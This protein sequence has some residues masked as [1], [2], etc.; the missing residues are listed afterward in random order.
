MLPA[1]GRLLASAA[2]G[3]GQGRV[4]PGRVV[5]ARGFHRDQ[6]EPA[7]EER[8][9]VL[10]L[11]RERTVAS[12][13]KMAFCS[14]MF[15]RIVHQQG[16]TNELLSHLPLAACV[17]VLSA[18]FSQQIVTRRVSEEACAVAFFLAHAF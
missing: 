4:A 8:G 2:S 14:D 13:A 5:P 11:T 7:G 18:R 1:Q 16:P 15:G 10:Q 3:G 9:H 17:E 12:L 6:L